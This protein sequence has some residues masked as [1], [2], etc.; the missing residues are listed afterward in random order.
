MNTLQ[1]DYQLFTEVYTCYKAKICR[2]LAK[3]KLQAPDNERLTT[4]KKAHTHG[5]NMNRT[6]YQ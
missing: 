6:H 3:M 2:F 1:I 5:M 4:L